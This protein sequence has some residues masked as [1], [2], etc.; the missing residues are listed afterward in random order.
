MMRFLFFAHDINGFSSSRFEGGTVVIDLSDHGLCKGFKIRTY[1][2]CSSRD[3]DRR[4]IGIKFVK[5]GVIKF[6]DKIG[7]IKNGNLV[8]V[9]RSDRVLPDTVKTIINFVETVSFDSTENQKELLQS[10]SS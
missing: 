2:L 4:N 3:E 7:Y 9:S 6:S 8:S 5:E 10:G 1:D